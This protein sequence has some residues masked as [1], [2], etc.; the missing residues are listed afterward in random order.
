M[1][2]KNKSIECRLYTD[3]DN[4][5]IEVENEFGSVVFKYQHNAINTCDD[6]GCDCEQYRNEYTKT[7]EQIISMVNAC[8]GAGICANMKD[9]IDHQAREIAILQNQTAVLREERD[10]ARTEIEHL[11]LALDHANDEV[12]RL[13]QAEA[14]AR[15]LAELS[16]N[17]TRD[18]LT[19][20]R[21]YI[22]GGESIRNMLLA[23]DNAA[24]RAVLEKHEWCEFSEE[25]KGLFC[26]ECGGL[27][28]EGHAPGCEIDR[29]LKK[30]KDTGGID[31]D[32]SIVHCIKCDIDYPN[33]KITNVPSELAM[34]P[35]CNSKD[36]QTHQ[37]KLTDEEMKNIKEQFK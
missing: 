22:A 16:M 12:E 17:I 36:S 20:I 27:E 28:R 1:G 21:A 5:G 34:C 7:A 19:Q 31:F 23:R 6:P 26:T 8:A 2:E 32:N 33:V 29:L 11:K 15:N 10:K 37:R 18:H 25:D 3:N 35:N 4:V 14:T 24:L 13:A 30:E 9:K